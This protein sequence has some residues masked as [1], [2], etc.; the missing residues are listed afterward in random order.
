M[1]NNLKHAQELLFGAQGLGASNFKMFPG[2][3]REVTADQVAAEIVK[4]L[5]EPI[6][7]SDALAFD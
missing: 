3:N 2:H 5:L 7:E 4:T 6:G 1:A